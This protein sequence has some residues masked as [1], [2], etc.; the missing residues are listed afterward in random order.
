MLNEFLIGM[1]FGMVIYH[2][3]SK[4]MVKSGKATKIKRLYNV[5]TDKAEE[6][7]KK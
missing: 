1:L 5:L 2:F 7:T 3:I 4:K 6:E